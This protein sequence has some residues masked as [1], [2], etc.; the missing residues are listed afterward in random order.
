[1]CKVFWTPERR[2]VTGVELS[3]F[4]NLFVFRRPPPACTGGDSCMAWIELT[5]VCKRHPTSSLHGTAVNKSTKSR[6][7]MEDPVTTIT[8]PEQGRYK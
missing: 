6:W 2:T 1:M 7:P 8:A 4:P 3:G 5:Q